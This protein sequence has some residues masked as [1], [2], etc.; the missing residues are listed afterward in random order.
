MDPADLMRCYDDVL[1]F[2]PDLFDRYRRMVDRLDNP[3]YLQDE[4]REEHVRYI[5]QGQQV[6]CTVFA[7]RDYVQGI[8]SLVGHGI[9]GA[10]DLAAVID[11]LA[12]NR[13]TV[14]AMVCLLELKRRFPDSPENHYAL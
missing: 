11:R 9:L 2:V 3:L 8:D 10:E 5:S 4:K 6:V 14:T 12:G 7:R 13:A 1:P